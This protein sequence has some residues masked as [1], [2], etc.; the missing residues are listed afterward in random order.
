LLTSWGTGMNVPPRPSGSG[1]KTAVN[2]TTAR[3]TSPWAQM[4][5]LD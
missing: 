4:F 1:C 5:D 2:L 3:D